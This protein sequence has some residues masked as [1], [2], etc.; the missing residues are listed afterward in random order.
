LTL[1]N[2][3]AEVAGATEAAVMPIRATK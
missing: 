2:A 1:A 3:I